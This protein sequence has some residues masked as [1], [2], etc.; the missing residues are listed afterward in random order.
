MTNHVELGARGGE[1]GNRGPVAPK[2][3]VVVPG[4]EKAPEVEEGAV[5]GHGMIVRSPT[6]W[7][8]WF[9][10]LFALHYQGFKGNIMPWQ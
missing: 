3:L 10:R 2:V 5:V 8:S 6:P 1:L 9:S 4:F 7:F